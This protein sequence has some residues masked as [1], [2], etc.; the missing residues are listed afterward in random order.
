MIEVTFPEIDISNGCISF[1]MADLRENTEKLQE[2]LKYSVEL[3]DTSGKTVTVENPVLVYH[4]L[5]VQ[6]YKQEVLAGKYEYK[7]QLQRV[8]IEP[9]MFGDAKFDYS[10]V[11]AMRIITDGTDAGELLINNIG[12]WSE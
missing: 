12:Y 4:S 1:E 5:A 10:K 6:L 3:E 11:V 9:S 7:H 8:A 2:G